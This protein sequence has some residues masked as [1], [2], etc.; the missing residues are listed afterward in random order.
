MHISQLF[1]LSPRGDKLAFKDFRQD[2]PRNSDEIFYR[3]Y[4]FWDGEMNQAP[5]GDCPPF[6]IEQGIHFCHVRRRQLLF[7]CTSRVI[8][9]PSSTVELLDRMVA[10]VKDYLGVLSEESIRRNFTLVYELWDEMLMLGV[11]QETTTERLRPCVLHDVKNVASFTS[12]QSLEAILERLKQADFS[13]RTKRSDAAAV[14]IVQSDDARNEVYI[15]V[16]ERLTATF[17]G[18]GNPTVVEVDGAVIIKSFLSGAPTLYLG[19]DEGI[20]IGD[21]VGAVRSR[22][23]SAVVDSMCF[24][25]AADTARFERERLVIMRPA[26]GE[27]TLLRYRATAAERI[28]VPFRLSQ[29]LQLLTNEKA[30]LMIR[31]VA[32]FPAEVSALETKLVVPLPLSTTHAS[33]EVGVG[34][35]NQSHEYREAE[36]EV[37]W[38]I[39]TF[40]GG[41][42]QVCKVRFS[43]AAPIT[44]AARREIGPVS[45]YFEIP[46]HTV[47]GFQIKSLRIEERSDAY[48][49]SRWL[50]S[51]T[52]ANSY[53]FRTH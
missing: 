12:E 34:G 4:N 27:T 51:M 53:V 21:S 52:Q 50:R 46:Q 33:L 14:S 41:T 16:L 26:V 3:K 38:A 6:F 43:T 5:L 17:D 23:A 37:H 48:N 10:V 44:N 35:S 20:E 24:H 25:D 19:L 1:I 32:E 30:E 31:V 15:D 40:S 42:E 7:V 36:K 29:S 45:M 11:P 28:K 8:D 18:A 2:V 22:Y 39:P 49:P 13:D 47:T 9:S